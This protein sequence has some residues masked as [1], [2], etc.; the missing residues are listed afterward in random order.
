MSFPEKGA[1]VPFSRRTL[2]CSGV[3]FFLNSS[4]FLGMLSFIYFI[5]L[6]KCKGK[7]PKT[8]IFYNNLKYMFFRAKSCHQSIKLILL[9]SYKSIFINIFARRLNGQPVNKDFHAHS[10]LGARNHIHILGFIT[11]S[12]FCHP[13]IFRVLVRNVPLPIKIEH[14]WLNVFWF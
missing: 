14:V 12:Y 10:I 5:C 9:Y 11:E 6:T 8:R 7:C 3:S 1:S 2:Y 4:S 13:F